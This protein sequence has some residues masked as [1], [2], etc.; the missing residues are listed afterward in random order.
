[1]S[2]SE[3]IDSIQTYNPEAFR[4][5]ATGSTED[6]VQLCESGSVSVTGTDSSGHSLFK[7]ELLGMLFLAI[8]SNLI[9]YTVCSG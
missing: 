1:M 5:A 7:G 8:F 4:T 6:L 2:R 9:K 3:H